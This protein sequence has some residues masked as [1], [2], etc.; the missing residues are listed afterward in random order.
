MKNAG[1]IKTLLCSMAVSAMAF[2]SSASWA[3][4]EFTPQAGNWIVSEELD[5]KPG[6]GLAIDVQGNTMFMQVFGY[7]KNGDATFHTALGQLNGNTVTAPLMRYRG[8]R[9]F[10][11]EAR[12]AAE[13]G[14]PGQVTV[15]FANGLQGTVQFPSEAPVAMERFMAMSEQFV[16]DTYSPRKVG[17]QLKVAALDES[18]QPVLAW[19]AVLFSHYLSLSQKVG[20]YSYRQFECK[21]LPQLEA[22]TCH[23]QDP[24]DK[25][26]WVSSVQLRVVGTDVQGRIETRQGAISRHYDLIGM[27]IAAGGEGIPECLT[28]YQIYVQ[29]S[30]FNCGNPMVIAPSSGIWVVTDELTGKPGRGLAIDVQNGVAIAQVFNYQPDGRPS[31]HMGSSDYEGVSTTMVLNRYADGRYFGAPQR[32]AQIV[33]TAGEL[34]L[35]FTEPYQA[36]KVESRVAGV[37]RFPGEQ[38]QRMQRLELEPDTSS[39]QGLLGQWMLNFEGPDQTRAWAETTFVTL[40]R[41]LGDMATNEDGSVQCRRQPQQDVWPLQS[42]VCEWWRADR[43]ETWKSRFMRQTNNRSASTMQI[44]DRHGN[45]MSLGSIPLPVQP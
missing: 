35:Q 9:A 21:E 27:A 32:S 1:N 2:A 10:G 19:D 15:S 20:Q 22:Y 23:G 30:P 29:T 25:S 18:G 36:N 37:V 5:G 43:A 40:S 17:R 42:T 8:G 28:Y 14:S 45:L 33:E 4:R 11:S 41:D 16:V 13:D 39:H 12:D 7:E 24:K 44:R 38:P 26:V 34:Q 6:R 3:A 31:F